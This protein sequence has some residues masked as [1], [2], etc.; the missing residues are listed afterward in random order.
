MV[1]GAYTR[2]IHN[3]VQAEVHAK[4]QIVQLHLSEPNHY[5]T[6][7]NAGVHPIPN[8][9]CKIYILFVLSFSAPPAPCDFM[10]YADV[11]V[12]KVCNNVPVTHFEICISVVGR[13]DV[14]I[15]V[16]ADMFFF[17]ITTD[18][19]QGAQIKVHTN[20]NVTQYLMYNI[21]FWYRFVLLILLELVHT[22]P[23]SQYLN[24]V[25]NGLL[26]N[27]KN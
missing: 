19:P 4:M 22:H 14:I 3:Y 17:L 26:D 2:V 5:F 20:S 10:V 13:A 6:K 8:M 12:W 25:S 27:V 24:L 1:L 7:I 23:Y 11:A 16:E 18:I 15:V 21:I 9:C